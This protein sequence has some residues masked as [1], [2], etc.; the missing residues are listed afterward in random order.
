[1][2]LVSAKQYAPLKVFD[3]S[4]FSE[5]EKQSALYSLE[6]DE[7]YKVFE[8]DNSVSQ[9]N[10][11]SSLLFFNLVK[12]AEQHY[13]LLITA[14]HLIIDGWSTPILLQALFDAYAGNE[15]AANQL[16]TAYQDVVM[17][18]AAR[19]TKEAEKGL[20]GGTHWCHTNYDLCR[21]KL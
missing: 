21:V 18:M 15:G 8:L 3:F 14:H 7:A 2:T 5:E 1:M 11:S 17:E 13:Q 16:T 9:P 19:S 10:N 12:M 20:E 4:E 6:M